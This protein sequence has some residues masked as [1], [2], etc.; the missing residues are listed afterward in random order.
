MYSVCLTST[1]D[2]SL[3]RL[4][5]THNPQFCYT[6]CPTSDGTVRALLLNLILAY[7][8][9]SVISAHLTRH[10]SVHL[11]CSPIASANRLAQLA[12]STGPTV[13]RVALHNCLQAAGRHICYL[14]TLRKASEV[15]KT[16]TLLLYFRQ[17]SVAY[18]TN[19][20]ATAAKADVTST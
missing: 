18:V 16:R 13:S 3:F 14:A 9:T 19:C 8:Y 4:Q 11:W 15:K 17:R 7:T 10:Q 2:L 5:P 20:K 6:F 12:L 1:L